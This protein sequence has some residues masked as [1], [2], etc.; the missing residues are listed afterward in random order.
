MMVLLHAE[1]ISTILEPFFNPETQNATMADNWEV[2]LSS[3]S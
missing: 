3:G 1:A 2:L